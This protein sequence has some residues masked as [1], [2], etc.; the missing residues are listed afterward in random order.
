MTLSYSIEQSR[1]GIN[2]IYLI[3]EVLNKEI[4]R[5][6]QVQIQAMVNPFIEFL[7][8]GLLFLD[9]MMIYKK[10]FVYIQGTNHTATSCFSYNL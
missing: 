10:Q 3:G 8:V 6:D 1:V 7:K 4:G 9:I 2:A 5:Q